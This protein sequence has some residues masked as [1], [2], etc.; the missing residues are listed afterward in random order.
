MN[1][2]KQVKELQKSVNK[3]KA[4]NS[5]RKVSDYN[6]FEEYILK[7]AEDKY[8][9]EVNYRNNSGKGTETGVGSYIMKQIITH[10]TDVV[11]DNMSSYL[12]KR[13]RRD[14]ISKYFMRHETYL[15]IDS[16]T[17]DKAEVKKSVAIA[18]QILINAI[19]TETSYEIVHDELEYTS[20]AIELHDV[21]NQ[22]GKAIIEEQV[23]KSIAM[24]QPELLT[25][26][27]RRRANKN[28]DFY[29][30]LRA[31]ARRNTAIDFIDTD[32]YDKNG[33]ERLNTRINE[34]KNDLSRIGMFF[35]EN[36]LAST[37]MFNIKILSNGTKKRRLVTFSEELSK[38]I[39]DVDSFNSVLKPTLLPIPTKFGK[40]QKW[41]NFHSGG[42]KHIKNNFIKKVNRN[43]SKQLD[44]KSY[45]EVFEAANNL[46]ETEYK[47]NTTVF[48][49]ILH[50]MNNDTRFKNNDNQ[51]ILPFSAKSMKQ[52]ISKL[53]DHLLE[54]KDDFKAFTKSVNDYKNKH[55]YDKK[56][57]RRLNIESKSKKFQSLYSEYK[58][59]QVKVRHEQEFLE[60]NKSK[61]AS[62]VLSTEIAKLMSD[63]SFCIPVNIDWRGRYYYMSML[64]PQTSDATKAMLSMSKTEVLTDED[65]FYFMFNCGANDYGHDKQHPDFKKDWVLKNIDKIADSG[66]N[67]LENIEFWGN[68]EKPFMF[69]NFCTEIAKWR[70]TNYTKLES[71]Y[72]CYFDGSVNGTQ[73]F[74]ALTRDYDTAKY[75]NLTASTE[76]FD[77]YSLIATSTEELLTELCKCEALEYVKIGKTE[78]LCSVVRFDTKNGE[79]LLALKLSKIE[80]AKQAL[81][82]GITRKLVKQNVMTLTYSSTNFGRI[83]QVSDVYKDVINKKGLLPFKQETIGK[84][85]SVIAQVC[86]AAI[87]KENSSVDVAMQ[88]IKQCFAV[89]TNVVVRDKQTNEI[90][91]IGLEAKWKTLCNSVVV[92][93]YNRTDTDI[94]SVRA[95]TKTVRITRITEI[96]EIDKEKFISAAI[97]NIVHSL[98]SSHMTKVINK[99]AKYF[100]GFACVH[101]SFGVNAKH[102]A[103]LYQIIRLEFYEMYNNVDYLSDLRESFYKQIAEYDLELA[104]TLPDAPKLGNYDLRECLNSLYSFL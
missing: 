13:M 96:D 79:K 95:G 57:P 11:V 6:S 58:E 81:K 44:Y 90:I 9:T 89:F 55:G 18:T 3:A 51:L 16:E 99:C 32:G 61:Y 20:K 10:A 87:A 63:D 78:E 60:T 97:A 36:I 82:Y 67:P 103:K 91:Q 54:Y 27:E 72:I 65:E 45:S 46:Q 92:Q 101:D 56:L 98:D 42:Y 24:Q 88:F 21:Y 28:S 34:A 76:R 84:K 75:S 15:S 83:K 30:K 104:N 59:H 7:T 85:A 47:I 17:V 73:H 68:A 74:A 49:T 1:I 52:E 29:I 93:K 19:M 77:L 71:N 2:N 66:D 53:P 8:F 40:P 25:S 70:S 80:D 100:T 41:T 37:D 35:I 64:N 48:D 23:I 5:F 86:S 22:V 38:N 12:D 69:L 39:Y 31:I 94:V 14:N 26:L 62:L 43:K 4:I 33:V 50:L 102:A